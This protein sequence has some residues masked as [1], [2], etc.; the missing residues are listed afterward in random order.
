MIELGHHTIRPIF[1]T[2]DGYKLDCIFISAMKESF[3]N[4]PTMLICN[5]NAACYESLYHDVQCNMYIK[6]TNLN[7]FYLSMGVNVMMWNYRGFGESEGTPDPIVLN[8]YYI[9]PIVIDE[10]WRRPN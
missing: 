4:Y 10:G 5:P 8:N 2:R 7:E 9:Y 1:R 6:Q 3:E